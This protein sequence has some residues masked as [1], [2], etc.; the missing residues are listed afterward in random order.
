MLVSGSDGRWHPVHPTL[1]NKS[2][3]CAA[4]RGSRPWVVTIGAGSAAW[5]IVA[6]VMSPMRSSLVTPS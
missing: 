2:A 4:A 3:P 1:L 6:A 5:N